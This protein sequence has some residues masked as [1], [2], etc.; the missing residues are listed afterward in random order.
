MDGS[1]VN[2]ASERLL[3]ATWDTYKTLVNHT[4]SLQQ[5]NAKFVREMVDDSIEELRRQAESNR[6]MTRELFELAEG[7]REAFREFVERSVLDTYT[8]FLFEPFT[9][10]SYYREERRS[11]APASDGSRSN[12]R[13]PIENYDRL[14]TREISES[15]EGLSEGEIRI[16]RS[17]EQQH[18]NRETLL[19]QMNRR[20]V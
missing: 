10:C 2:E 12:G 16:V 1:G 4:L 3:E 20:L 18:K 5:R 15:L 13:L 11:V 6:V 19:R 17:Y 7:Q 14:T 9:P 8:N